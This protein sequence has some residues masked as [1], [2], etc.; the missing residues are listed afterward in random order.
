MGLAHVGSSDQGELAGRSRKRRRTSSTEVDSNTHTPPPQNFSTDTAHMEAICRKL[1]GEMTAKWREEGEQLRFELRHMETR[2]KDWVDER[3]NKCMDD[4][5]DE[6]GRTSVQQQNQIHE[7][8]QEVRLELQEV[9]EEAQVVDER[10]EEVMEEV[11][12]FR[13]DTS[14]LVD[15]RLDERL[16]GLQSE[17]EEYVA[18]QLSDVE[19][20]VMDRLRSNV[21]IDFGIY[22]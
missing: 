20:R 19:D 11:Q 12:K 9:R 21:Y 16:E 6:I 10:S 15:G 18:E 22:D 13:D 1:M 5:R 8:V 14:D 4:I 3:L 2:M 17:L 7:Q